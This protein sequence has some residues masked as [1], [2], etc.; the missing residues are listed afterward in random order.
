[1]TLRVELEF[2][3]DKKQKWENLQNDNVIQ[4]F[5]GFRFALINN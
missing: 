1:M 2:H 3:R 5:L 4:N